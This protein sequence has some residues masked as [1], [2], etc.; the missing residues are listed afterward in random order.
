[1]EILNYNIFKKNFK[2]IIDFYIKDLEQ[3]RIY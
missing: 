2:K 1:M 3:T